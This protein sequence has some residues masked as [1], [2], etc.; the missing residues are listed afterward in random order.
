M[1][2]HFLCLQQ[3]TTATTK[4]DAEVATEK[5]GLEAGLFKVRLHIGIAPDPCDEAP[6]PLIETRPAKALQL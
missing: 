2:T 4:S 1:Y 3:E 5:Y 6:G